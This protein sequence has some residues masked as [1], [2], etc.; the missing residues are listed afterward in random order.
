MEEGFFERNRRRVKVRRIRPPRNLDGRR[1]AIS[2]ARQGLCTPRRAART[3]SHAS[4]R[5]GLCTPRRA[6]PFA[7]AGDDSRS[8]R[9][10]RTARTEVI[11]GGSRHLR[12]CM[13]APAPRS[14]IVGGFLWFMPLAVALALLFLTANLFSFS[15]SLNFFHAH[16]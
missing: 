5:Q 9:P 15:P 14:G 2:P 11:C 1:T 4:A 12:I 16:F 10:S 7:S 13:R 3:A 6:A 8:E